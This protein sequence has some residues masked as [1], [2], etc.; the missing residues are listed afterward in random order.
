[1]GT[2]PAGGVG[3]DMGAGFEAGADVAPEGAF[4]AAEGA[5]VPVDGPLAD[6][7]VTFTPGLVA[8]GLT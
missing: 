2:W 3:V 8:A 1:M 6:T 7:K 4:V 5:G